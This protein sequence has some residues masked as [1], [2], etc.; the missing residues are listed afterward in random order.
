MRM[1]VVY[2]TIGFPTLSEYT[3]FTKRLDDAGVDYLEVGLPPVFA[4]YDGPAIRRSYARVRSQNID[5]FEAL[6]LTRRLTSIPIAVLTYLDDWVNSLD[7]LLETLSALEVD[8]VLFPDLLI[9]YLD[10]S[11][12]IIEKIREAGLKSILFVA[13]SMPDKLISYASEKSN[14]FLYFGLRPATG[15]ALPVDYASLVKRARS[16]VSN[17]L[18]VG[19]GLSLRDVADVVRAGADGVA[20]GSAIVEA[21]ESG[22]FTEAIRVVRELRGV[23]DGV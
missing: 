23:L 17:K 5:V 20:I 2:N 13:P 22:G 8:S 4:K 10:Q 1:L 9:D 6:R 15:I 11:E 7:R 19:F 12:V 14:P 18:I 21:L 16:L 3:E